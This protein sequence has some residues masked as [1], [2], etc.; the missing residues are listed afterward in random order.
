M[1]NNIQLLRNVGLFNSFAGTRQTAFGKLTLI[2]AENGKG[3]TTLSAIFRSLSN[4]DPIYI[5]ERQRLSSTNLPHVAIECSGATS[6]AIFQNNNWSRTYP[7]IRIFDDN[8]V[9]ENIYSGLEVSSEHRQNLHQV[10]IGSQGVQLARRVDELTEQISI[11]QN[12]LR[13]GARSFT[14]DILGPLTIDEFCALTPI[15]N[16][17]TAITQAGQRVTAMQQTEAVRTTQ[18]FEPFEPPTIDIETIRALLQRKL[19]NIDTE[20]LQAVQ[21]HLRQFEQ[22]GEVWVSQ[23]MEMV[24]NSTRNQTC[25]FCDQS[26]TGVILINHYRAYFSE[27]YAAH[28]TAISTQINEI[29]RILGEDAFIIFNRL[30]TQQSERHHFW[31][32]FNTLERFSIDVGQITNA[33]R[34]LRNQL[35]RLLQAKQEA[36]L[37]EV[38]IETETTAAIQEYE[39]LRDSV[40]ELSR[41]FLQVNE[42]IR[43]LKE[44]SS[45]GSLAVATND[46]KRLRAVK[47]RFS[48][49][50]VPLCNAYIEAKQR[51][52]VVETQKVQARE[53]LDQYRATVFPRYQTTI[54]E[55]LRKFNAGFRI[56]EVQAINPRGTSSSTYQI[57]IDNCRIPLSQTAPGGPAFKNTLSAGDRNT[58]ALAFFFA[59]LDQE[60]T[61]TSMAIII[62]DPVS[63]LDEGRT[64]T[65]AQE[66]RAFAQRAE[67]VILLSHSRQI[68]CEVWMFA[69]RQNC[70]ALCVEPNAGGS[71]IKT[72]DVSKE[73]ITE[74]DRQHELLRNYI[75]GTE[76]NIREVAK[77]LRHVLEGYLRVVATEYFLPGTMIGQFIRRAKDLEKSGRTIMDATAIK[78]LEAILQYA[79]RFHHEN[80]GWDIALNN[81]NEQELQGFT[82]RT[83][84]FTKK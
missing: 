23:G 60:Q 49:T 32:Q 16:I 84:V 76:R 66:I 39:T 2:Y 42:N 79:N 56:V 40:R 22:A 65:T 55:Y 7:H 15:D 80:Q 35:I 30:I 24:E 75:Q 43:K 18:P 54:N 11:A 64:I 62:D 38:T 48:D 13:T 81:I 77:S 9:H 31:S 47:E 3:K 5:T 33:W 34:N 25:P 26:L 51:K 68:L 50:V 28:K 59:S 1:I 74:Y 53:A 83:L 67:Q 72:W 29:N 63:S 17:D 78:E 21:A 37:E 45:T 19:S 10:I 36:P 4:G 70:S 41:S 52:E 27:A 71:I 73:S 46:L 14:A 8:F 61:L 12:E 69:D 6:P 57:E 20:A 58:L 44:E 82:N